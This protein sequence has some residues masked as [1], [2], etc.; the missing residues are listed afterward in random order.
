MARVQ[1]DAQKQQCVVV[2]LAGGWGARGVL[3]CVTFIIAAVLFNFI[4]SCDM[5][6]HAPGRKPSRLLSQPMPSVDSQSDAEYCVA[7][8]LDSII[9]LPALG[10]SGAVDIWIISVNVTA[11][12]TAKDSIVAWSRLEPASAQ[13]N[14]DRKPRESRKQ[15]NDVSQ[16]ELRNGHIIWARARSWCSTQRSM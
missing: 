2:E 9:H 6:P 8:E 4:A 15:C 7:S 10:A 5:V 12:S 13:F 1:M 16:N 11:T 3:I 14:I